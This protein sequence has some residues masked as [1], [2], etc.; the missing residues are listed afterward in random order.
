MGG[1]IPSPKCIRAKGK[2]LILALFVLKG[3]A[4]SGKRQK[5]YPA[6]SA[7]TGLQ[8][9]A[10]RLG[11]RLMSIALGMCEQLSMEPHPPTLKELETI[12]Q[13]LIQQIE[14]AQRLFSSDANGHELLAS[15]SALICIEEAIKSALEREVA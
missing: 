11:D 5:G 1:R 12:R 4:S 14:E 13:K 7:K 3:M 6:K 8:H 9:P 2:R 15:K 10:A